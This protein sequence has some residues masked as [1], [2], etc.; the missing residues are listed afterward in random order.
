M[1]PESPSKAKGRSS[2]P[3]IHQPC[4][5]CR[6]SVWSE[7][8]TGSSRPVVLPVMAPSLW[9]TMRSAGGSVSRSRQPVGIRPEP[10]LGLMLTSGL[11]LM[12]AASIEMMVGVSSS[13]TQRRT[14]PRARPWSW[15]APIGL[16]STRVLP[17][18][19]GEREPQTWAA[20][21][22]RR[23]SG[24]TETYRYQV[25]QQLHPQTTRRCKLVFVYQFAPLRKAVDE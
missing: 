17:G 2:S 15:L 6:V 19:A 3:M 13:G 21:R 11:G 4:V 20:V 10:L 7:T 25:L 9:T 22:I 8:T 1:E 5:Y 12:T 16:C 24:S 23:V 18:P 14:S